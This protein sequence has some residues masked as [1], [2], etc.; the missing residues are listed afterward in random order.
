MKRSWC[1][2]YFLFYILLIWGAYAPCPY[3][4]DFTTPSAD[5]TWRLSLVGWELLLWWPLQ[6][7]RRASA[8][9]RQRLPLRDAA[10]SARPAPGHLATP[11]T[12]LGD[13]LLRRGTAKPITGSSETEHRPT[14]RKQLRWVRSSGH[15]RR[16]AGTTSVVFLAP[17]P[18]I[19]LLQLLR[20]VLSGWRNVK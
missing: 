4:S 14:D 5:V 13:R 16:V 9:Q 2:T 20:C 3:G 12:L 19:A 17:L 7:H 15:Y 10:A 11:G 6:Q 1:W 8:H 18:P